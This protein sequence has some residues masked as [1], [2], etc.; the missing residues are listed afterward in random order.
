MR[1]LY[2]RYSVHPATPREMSAA[3]ALLELDSQEE[4]QQETVIACLVAASG[5]TLLGYVELV[6]YS[7][8]H[9]VS[10]GYW[11]RRLLIKPFFRGM[12]IGEALTLEVIRRAEAENADKLY[13]VVRKSNERAIRLYQKMGF[14]WD[15]FP[16]MQAELERQ[17]QFDQ[18]ARVVMMKKLHAYDQA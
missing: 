1:I 5:S 8:D 7:Q 6:R 17:E 11:L 14:E 18:H 3:H 13:L 9:P 15:P 2:A 10:P 4:Q 12:G 16:P